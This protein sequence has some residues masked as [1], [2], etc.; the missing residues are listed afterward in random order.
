MKDVTQ[1]TILVHAGRDP[2]N[3]HGIVNPPVYHCS[4]VLFPTLDALEESDRNTLEGVHYGR[5][6]TPTTF[7]FEEAAAALEES[8]EADLLL[9]DLNMP[10]MQ[11]FAGLVYLCSRFPALPI[12]VI[13]ANEE[14]RVIRRALGAGACGYIPKSAPSDMLGE[15][16][17]ALLAGELWRPALQEPDGAGMEED[18]AVRIASLTPQQVRVLMMLNDG[19]VNKQI[20]YELGV[21]EGTVKAHVSAILQKLGVTSRTQAVIL[22]RQLAEDADAPQELIRRAAEERQAG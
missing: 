12:A 20:A 21:S 15:A 1:D 6:G 9:L 10:G 14:P 13:S 7:A 19:L 17:Q 22:V 11:G 18:A 8:P 3:N 2:R 5:M 4:T 16:L